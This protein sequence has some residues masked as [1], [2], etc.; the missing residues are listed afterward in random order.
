MHHWHIQVLTVGLICALWQSVACGQAVAPAPAGTG[1]VAV[2]GRSPFKGFAPVST[3]AVAAPGRSPFTGFT[4]VTTGMVGATGRNPFKEF[5]TAST[6]AVRSTFKGF[7][8]VATGSIPLAVADDTESEDLELEDEFASSGTNQPALVPSVPESPSMDT[9]VGLKYENMDVEEVL[10]QYAVWTGLALMRAP[11][12]PA[13]KITLKCPKRLPKR[14]ALLAIEGVLAMNGIA[15]VPMGDKFLKVV[16]IGAAR[17]QGMAIGTGPMEKDIVDTD[18]LVSRIVELKHLEMA[19]AQATIQNLL[20]SYGKVMPLERV[21]C[22]LITET[23]LNLKRILEIL[24]IIDQPLESREELRIFPITYAK[25]SEI[26]SKIESIIADVQAKESKNKVVRQQLT[27]RMPLQPFQPLQPG[28]PAMAQTAVTDVNPAALDRGLIQS[29][30]KMVADDRINSL[31]VITRPEQLSFF[32]NIIAA[33]DR[34]VEPEVSIKVFALEYADSK[35]VVGVLNNLLG[36][37]SS[38]KTAGTPANPAP[39][40]ASASTSTFGLPAAAISTTESKKSTTTGSAGEIQLTGKLSSEVK[41][42]ADTRINSLLVLAS[43]SDMAII[44]DVLRQV[45]IM[46]SQVLIEV[47]IVEIGL[48]DQIK[49]GIDWLQRSMIAYNAKQGGGRNAVVGFGGASRS[50][51]DAT[52]KDG[53][54]INTIGDLPAGAG[55]GLTYYLKFFDYNI[56][57]V[58]NMLAS[59]SEARILS[60]PIILT[61]D[62]KEAKIMVGEKRPV[63]TGSSYYSGQQSST[64]QYVDIGIQLEVTPR[65]N[66]KGFVIMDIKQKIDNKGDDVTIDGNKVPVITTRDFTASVSVNDGRTIVIGGIVSSDSNK[67]RSKIPFLGD[68]PF[69]GVLFRS[70]D[71]ETTR[72]ELIVLMTPYV[73]NTP[74]KAYAETARRHG[75]ISEASNLWTKGWSDSTLAA[76]SAK[77]QKEMKKQKDALSRNQ[78][79]ASASSY[80]SREVD[81]MPELPAGGAKPPAV[82]AEEPTSPTFT[83]VSSSSTKSTK[84]APTK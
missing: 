37:S 10:G 16:A 83:P 56:D 13:V 30:V 60:T 45:D 39:A 80:K 77:E 1:T 59:A 6:G 44:E 22:L 66:K 73:L 75:Y 67:S 70:D 71:N 8:P 12:V 50:G 36:G 52:L 57:A 9:L 34:K 84:G 42:I 18:R 38:S 5:A 26:Q 76:P 29:K 7:M 81:V 15:L 20:H 19:E 3:G 21:N 53:S 41:I 79:P 82:K 61:T 24:A 31:I 58:I 62:N 28:Q 35:D 69:L 43:R 23:A 48:N 54:S 27:T 47:V 40:S 72:R 4:P 46:L 74:E 51:A 2:P 65:I 68:I 25:A 49:V 11:D 63:M 64:Y 78:K 55:S 32:T 17:Q 14:E 33:L